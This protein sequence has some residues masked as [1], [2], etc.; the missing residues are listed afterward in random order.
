MN[1]SFPNKAIQGLEFFSAQV[2]TFPH[3][4]SSF[5]LETDAKKSRLAFLAAVT[6][7]MV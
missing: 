6:I 4:T 3:I 2:D 5:T 7:K 1:V